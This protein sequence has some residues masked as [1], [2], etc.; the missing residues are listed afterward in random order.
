MTDSLAHNV[1]GLD[2]KQQHPSE[3]PLANG[4]EN[5]SLGVRDSSG[6]FIPVNAFVVK[7]AGQKWAL[8]L[9]NMPSAAE[10]FFE[11]DADTGK[12]KVI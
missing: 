5:V 3:D 7:H 12:I 9:A 11:K 2:L 6:A 1:N 8:H 4:Q 10:S